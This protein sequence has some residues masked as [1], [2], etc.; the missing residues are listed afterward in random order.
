MFVLLARRWYSI[1]GADYYAVNSSNSETTHPRIPNAL[2]LG[3]FSIEQCLSLFNFSSLS[4]I[5]RR[6]VG[7]AN[8]IQMSEKDLR[9][10]SLMP[11]SELGGW[12][13]RV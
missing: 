11:F 7:R 8:C 9:R 2:H 13:L 10:Y 12:R 5:P 6:L 4:Q 1:L 3:D